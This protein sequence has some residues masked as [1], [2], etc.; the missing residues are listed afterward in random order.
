MITLASI[1][2]IFDILTKSFKF[3]HVHRISSILI[4]VC[5]IT[6]LY[7]VFNEFYLKNRF[8]EDVKRTSIINKKIG[9]VV[10]SCGVGSY[11]SWS[12]IS[13]LELGNI[14]RK[15]S[16]NDVIGCLSEDSRH[17]PVSVKYSNKLYLEE[18][19][20]GLDDYAHF[21]S[22]D[23]AIIYSCDIINRQV[24]CPGY[25]PLFLKDIVQ[26]TNLELSSVNFILVKNWKDD[27]IYIFTLSFSASSVPTCTK[28]T[29]N[30][31]LESLAR[32]AIENL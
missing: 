10:R 16:F 14:G 7:I 22:A 32:T 13:N 12:T 20:L 26:L 25:T 8:Y 2:I 4:G 3:C 21:T 24:K 6:T 1:K 29:G 11:V 17:C 18:R 9:D 30:I 31:L 23:D 5:A 28:Q 27:L 15:V 19:R